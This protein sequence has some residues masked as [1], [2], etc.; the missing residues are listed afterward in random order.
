MIVALGTVSLV[1][2]QV[3]ATQAA[4]RL[5]WV[6]R[7]APP[8]AG[9]LVGDG[10]G[11]LFTFGLDTAGTGLTAYEYNPTSNAWRTR[12]SYLYDASDAGLI[13]GES[14]TLAQDGRIIVFG[15]DDANNQD[16]STVAA[17]NPAHNTWQGLAPLPIPRYDAAA[18]TVPQGKIYAIGGDAGGDS[19]GQGEVTLTSVEAYSPTKDAW[20]E[21]SPLN[22]P[23]SSL[24][25]RSAP[26]D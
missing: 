6:T 9:P 26:T 13:I 25:L 12:A 14:A 11:D 15:G 18:V 7:T 23:A 5:H 3:M 1:L 17:F 20:V 24:Q 22:D 21:L 16:I 10:H 8:A 2:G 19:G 4:T